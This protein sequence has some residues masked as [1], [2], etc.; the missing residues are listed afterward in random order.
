MDKNFAADY[1]KHCNTLSI[2]FPY[3]YAA[4]AVSLNWHD[5]LFAINSGFLSFHAAIEHAVREL[6]RNEAASQ[7]V[8]ELAMLFFD[9]AFPFSIHPYIDE[10]SEQMTAEEKNQS[11]DKIM[12]VLLKWVYDN[13]SQYDDPLGVVEVI[14]D[15]FDF[16]RLM[17]P[18]VRYLPAQGALPKTSKQAIAGLYKKW[19]TFL[20]LQ[21]DKWKSNLAK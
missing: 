20:D 12:Y 19:K 5:I 3:S 14:F 11:K 16:P 9:T 7:S 13:K 1:E 17:T 18:F 4:E 2:S 6:E 10:L 8:L 15:D 21:K